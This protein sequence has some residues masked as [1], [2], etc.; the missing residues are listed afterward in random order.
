MHRNLRLHTS[1][2]SLISL[3][4]ATSTPARRRKPRS[5][6]FLL[7][8]GGARNL[9]RSGRE[10]QFLC[11][12]RPFCNPPTLQPPS[13]P[14]HGHLF[15]NQIRTLF[16]PVSRY[17]SPDEHDFLGLEKKK[18]C[19][20]SMCRIPD[21]WNAKEV[22]FSLGRPE[23]EKYPPMESWDGL[24]DKLKAWTLQFFLVAW[25]FWPDNFEDWL[26]KNNMRSSRQK[27]SQL[28]Y[29]RDL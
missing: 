20:L 14:S 18:Q 15:N 12:G 19:L 7:S 16:Y 22:G 2:S 21:R 6:P 9:R 3:R 1:F 24:C 5:Q 17:Q 10:C 26:Y 13:H 4:G 27:S 28:S 23:I 11:T 25:I 29:F 8:H